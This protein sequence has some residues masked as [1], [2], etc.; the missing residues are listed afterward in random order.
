MAASIPWNELRG[1]KTPLRVLDPMAGSGT[2]LVVARRLGHVSIG[3]DTD[4]LAVLLARAW[5]ADIRDG[6]ILRRAEQVLE[7]AKTRARALRVRDA[8]PAAADE[9]TREFVRYWFDPTNRRQLSALA[10]TIA[11]IANRPVRDVLWC[12]FSRMIITKQAGASLALDVAHSRPHKVVAKNVICPLDYFLRTVRAVLAVAPFKSNAESTPRA[13]VKLADARHLPLDAG[14]V[15][16]VISSPPYVNAIDYLRA[17]KFSLVWMGHA[18]GKLRHVRAANIGTEVSA[19]VDVE[20]PKIAAALK[21]M[22]DLERLP[23]R[24]KK[25]LGRFVADMG[26]TVAEM[27]RVLVPGGRAVLVV[28]DCTMRGVFVCNSG[29]LMYLSE[30]HGFHIAAWKRRKLPPNRRYLPPPSS[31][32]SGTKLQNRLR[33][34]VLLHLVKP[35]A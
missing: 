23:L 10:S 34:E 15:D 20:D 13:T 1:G 25:W 6:L 24:Q 28:G 7:T 31:R 18:I 26:K 30:Q 21:Q 9:E 5:C 17:H 32:D 12:A 11:E 2:T 35:A 3:F 19:D 27:H 16:I 8:Y 4:P 14:S 22:G 33:T 29:A